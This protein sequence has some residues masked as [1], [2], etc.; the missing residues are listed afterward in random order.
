MKF[1]VE[2][3][4]IRIDIDK[5]YW[6]DIK[7]RM[8]Y[9]DQQRLMGCFVKVQQGEKDL[10]VRNLDIAGGNIALLEINIKAWNLT[11]KDGKDMPIDK[12]SIDMLDPV[13]AEKILKEIGKQNPAP[14]A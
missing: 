5:D 1:F 11:G 13:V 2:D 6:V 8:S 3:E 14:K 4:V 7:K 9:G 10:E 12:A